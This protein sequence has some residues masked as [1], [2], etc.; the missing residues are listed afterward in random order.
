MSDD[1]FNMSLR[2]FLKTVGVTSQQ[3][4]EAAVRAAAAEGRLPAGKLTARAVI[5]IDEIGL[6]HEISGQ[7]DTD[8]G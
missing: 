7:I 1:S 5:T 2:K 4:I 6:S 8:Q 3:E